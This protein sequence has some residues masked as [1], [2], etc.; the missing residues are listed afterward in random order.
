MNIKIFEINL[1]RVIYRNLK[2]GFG[3]FY[4]ELRGKNIT[5]QISVFHTFRDSYQYG[6][7]KAYWGQRAVVSF[8]LKSYTEHNNK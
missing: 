3:G 8:G 4:S 7:D 6:C 2:L 5:C 1:K